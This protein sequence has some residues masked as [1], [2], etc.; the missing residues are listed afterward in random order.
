M[1]LSDFS[2]VQGEPGYRKTPDNGPEALCIRFVLFNLRDKVQL[3]SL[4]DRVV[5]D[6]STVPLFCQRLASVTIYSSFSIDIPL[7]LNHAS[8]ASAT[9]NNDPV[10]MMGV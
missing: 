10:M 5:E 9:V 8:R 7:R 2:H 3:S 6:G 1:V 4:F